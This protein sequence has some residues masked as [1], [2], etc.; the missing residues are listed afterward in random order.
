MEAVGDT[1]AVEGTVAGAVEGTVAVDTVAGAAVD[2]VA[3]AAGRE[4]ELQLL[5]PCLQ[6][7]KKKT[8]DVHESK[9][10]LKYTL[11]YYQP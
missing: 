2:T 9:Q 4:E 8:N 5:L 10:T 3:G 7:E 6:N 1:L 11:T